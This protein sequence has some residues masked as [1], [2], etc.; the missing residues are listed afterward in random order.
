MPGREPWE[1]GL[2]REAV[3]VGEERE[4]ESAVRGGRG[5]AEQRRGDG[6]GGHWVGF[7]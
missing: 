3:E 5:A 7:G 6:G 2:R 4:D 1:R